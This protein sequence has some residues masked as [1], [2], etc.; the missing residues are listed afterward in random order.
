MTATTDGSLATTSAVAGM[1]SSSDIS[2]T[3]AP[4]C[5]MT[6]I[7]TPAFSIRNSPSSKHVQRVDR[8]AVDQQRF[9]RRKIPTRELLCEREQLLHR[10]SIACGSLSR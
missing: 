1:P 8:F 5:P 10:R 3:H 6:A 2:P 7:G 9:T 4:G